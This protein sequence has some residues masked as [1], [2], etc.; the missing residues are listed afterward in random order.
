[1]KCPRRVLFGYFLA[2]TVV[3]CGLVA[4]RALADDLQSKIV[5]DTSVGWN[6]YG[7]LARSALVKDPT[8]PGGTAERVTVDGKGAN[9]WDAGASSAITK[10]I[11]QGDV[12]LL[13]FWAK[14]QEGPDGSDGVDIVAKLQ[15][16]AAPYTG[17]SADTTVHVGTKWKMYYV[18]G[19]ASKN[20]A[21]GSIGAQLLLATGKQVID[22]GP[23]FVLNFG[24]NYDQQKLP[25]N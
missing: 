18:T 5:N 13:A 3:F 24:P 17:L 19:K 14:A 21:S 12:L 2:I 22:F 6:V 1:M 9:P 20:Y 11:A 23:I 16:S 4:G 8:A 15:E 7:A 10:P 25:H